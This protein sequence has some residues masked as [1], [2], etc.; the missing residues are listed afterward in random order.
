[1]NMFSVDGVSHSSESLVIIEADEDRKPPAT[2]MLKNKDKNDNESLSQQFAATDVS[3]K[4]VNENDNRFGGRA[5][6]NEI[7]V[8]SGNNKICAKV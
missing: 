7:K 8:I 2:R 1:M 6:K 4:T 3:A 5:A